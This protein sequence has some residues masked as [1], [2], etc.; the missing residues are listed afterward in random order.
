MSLHHETTRC[1]VILSYNVRLSIVVIHP[2]LQVCLLGGT[3][4]LFQYFHWTHP[5][6]FGGGGLLFGGSKVEFSGSEVEFGG[7]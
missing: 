1:H 2:P 6:S 7:C 4:Y 3:L 5:H